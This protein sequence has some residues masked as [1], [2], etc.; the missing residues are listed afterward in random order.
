MIEIDDAGGWHS[1]RGLIARLERADTAS[2]ADYDM[3]TC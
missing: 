1:S 3:H 2:I